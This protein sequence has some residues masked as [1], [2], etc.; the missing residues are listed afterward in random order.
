LVR[1]LGLGALLIVEILLLTLRYDT[2]SLEG[3]TASWAL[4][5]EELPQILRMAIAAIAVMLLVGGPRLWHELRWAYPQLP[6]P[7]RWWPFLLCHLGALAIFVRL[8]GFILGGDGA[9]LSSPYPEAWI[10]LWAAMGAAVLGS[11]ALAVFPARI[12]L[13]LARRGWPEL[14]VALAGG[15]AAWWLGMYLTQFWRVMAKGTLWLAAGLLRWL[16][17]DVICRPRDL[18]LGTPTFTVFISPECSGYEGIGL[19]TVLVAVYC[20]LFRHRLR[21]PHALLL[22]PLGATLI[23]LVNVVRIAGLVALGSSGWRE[24][25]AGGFHSQAGWLAFNFVAL[26]LV[27]VAGR[28]RFFAVAEPGERAGR[29]LSPTVA[30]LAPLTAVA[31]VSMM[32]TAFASGF[33]WFYP[34]RV[35]AGGGAL[36]LCRRA[37]PGWRWSWSWLA[38]GLGAVTFGLWLALAPAGT[39]AA[40]SLPAPLEEVPAG[41]AAAWLVCRVLGYVVMTPLVEELAF[42]GYLLR[43]L[44]ALDFQAVSPRRFSWPAFLVTS[45]LFGALHGAYWLPGTLAGMAF[46]LAV[47][48]RGRLTDA[49]LAHATVNA[50]I[51]GYV[52]AT[53]SWALWS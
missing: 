26:G 44:I 4:L 42:R 38:F 12:W 46:A 23:W 21:F 47:Y 29:G 9:I 32:T 30:Y 51:A 11:W 20:S 19:I 10:T 15:V 45:G 52:L 2:G 35:A 50:L 18:L 16:Y 37:Y 22:F 3:E 6:Q 1:W 33:D 43:R 27:G 8:T 28:V 13:R 17:P 36:W 25:A 14:L 49:I 31:A 40:T 24:V 39:T 41:W 7:T 48:R 5:V 53:G 34:L